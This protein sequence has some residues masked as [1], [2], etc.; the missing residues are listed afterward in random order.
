MENA[1]P[2]TGS[3]VSYNPESRSKSVV[4]EP[5]SREPDPGPSKKMDPAE[6]RRMKINAAGDYFRKLKEEKE[7]QERDRIREQ[8]LEQERQRQIRKKMQ[9]QQQN[10]MKKQQLVT[11]TQTP[12]QTPLQTPTQAVILQSQTHFQVQGQIYLD[13]SLFKNILKWY[14]KLFLTF[15]SSNTFLNINV[16]KYKTFTIFV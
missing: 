10:R 1:N 13:Y 16:L 6:L 14:C 4:L 11:P 8:E 7:R 12:T 15:L 3:S 5:R 2:S 9:M